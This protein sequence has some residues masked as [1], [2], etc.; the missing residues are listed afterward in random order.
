M[1]TPG[2]EQ[3]FEAG[4]KAHQ[5]GQRAQ[6]EALYRQALAVDPRHADSMHLL[7]VTLE[8]AQPNTDEPLN[9]IQRAIALNPNV[10]EYYCNLGLF[11]AGRKQYQKSVDAFRRAIT[12][13]PQYSTAYCHLGN[14]LHDMGRLEESAN[15]YRQAVVHKND[16]FLAYSNLGNVLRELNRMG[17][18]AEMCRRAIAINP[19]FPGAHN[20]L[21]NALS[22]QDRVDEAIASYKRALELDPGSAE[23]RANIADL[24]KDMCRLDEAVSM[25][26]QALAIHPQL[27]GCYSNLLYD[28]HYRDQFDAIEIL[29]ESRNWDRMYVQPNAQFIRHHA[30]SRDPNRKLV[31]G[32]VS[33]DFRQHSVAAFMLP[34]LQHHDHSQFQIIGYSNVR[35]PDH[36]T[37]A[38]KGCVDVW[39]DLPG[40]NDA[41]AAELVRSDRVDILIDLAG[42]TG[43]NRLLMMSHK[44]A[45]VQLT[46]LGYPGTT[47]VSTIDYK[48]TDR[49]A[50]PPGMTEAHYSEKLLYLPRS[51]W[52]F[53]PIIQF[54]DVTPL[55]AN[56][57]G[58]ICF[59]SFSNFAKMTPK[60]FEMWAAI[61]A[62]V[63]NSKL[64]IKAK[65]LAMPSVRQELHDRFGKQGVDKSRLDLRPRALNPE[66]HL[67]MYGLVDIALDTFPYHGTT[68]T[69]EA[70]WMGVPVVSLAGKAHVS[71]VGVSLL[72]SMGLTELIAQTPQ[73]YIEIAAKLASDLARLSQLRSEL[74]QRMKDSPLMDA[75]GYAKEMEEQFRFVW[76]KWCEIGEQK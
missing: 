18:S 39:R 74:R 45:P 3:F 67:T 43:Q 42:H 15:A 32:Y 51:N 65:A 30:N 10:P 75:P 48:L 60:L 53:Q 8:M 37:Q 61:L 4:L 73:E 72:T 33:P 5:A 34:L 69:C 19:N 46:F 36:V 64:M 21:G 49:L 38:I 28:L 56:A 2:A 71:R 6:A 1:P 44:P 70:M 13:R 54:P 40:M 47:G 25:C 27:S 17:E 23:I 22:K 26:R 63:P 11:L 58:T 7:G 12:L 52:C 62:R 55:P 20:N 16:H 66:D 29:R 9:L 68:T 35:A 14:V 57:S 76:R 31:I 24:T 50:D 41:Q 59:G